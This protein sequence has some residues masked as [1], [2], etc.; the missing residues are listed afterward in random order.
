MKLGLMGRI[1]FILFLAVIFTSKSN[2]QFQPPFQDEGFFNGGFGMTWIDGEPYYNVRIMPEIAFSNIGIGIDLNLEFDSNGNLRTE[3]FNTVEDYIRIIRYFRYGYKGDPVHFRI[4]SLDW[5]TMGHGS[6]M[7]LYNNSPSFD[8]R[9]NGAVLDLDFSSLGVETIFSNFTQTNIMGMRAFVRPLQFTSLGGIPIIGKMEIG[10][11]YLTDMTENVGAY[12]GYID[13]LT[14]SFK[15]TVDKGNTTIYGF[16][17]GLPILRTGIVNI[18]AFYDY[19]Q[20]ADYGHGNSFGLMADFHGFGLLDIR[21]KFERRIN[22]AHYLPAYFN[23]LYEIE[24]FNYNLTTGEV[25]SKRMILDSLTESTKGWYGELLVS[26]L[27]TFNVLGSY[28]RLDDYANSGIL[29]LATDIAPDALPFVLRAGYDK[30]NINSESD[31]FT[32]DERS[33]VYAEV[34]YKIMTYILVSM[35]YQWTFEPIRDADNRIIDYKTQKRVE[36]RVSFYYPFDI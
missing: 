29:H 20:I 16:D 8:A 27:G 32:I 28:Q 24:R 9:K 31:I 15:A 7:Y 2:A 3:N 11:T 26:L 33:R 35:Y 19:V 1:F 17:F 23:S 21:A 10:A 34:G 12:E 6:I 36:P 4:G 13:P 5:V 22:G 25:A 18:D 30:T 14:G